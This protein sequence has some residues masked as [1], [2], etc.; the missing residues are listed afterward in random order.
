[1]SIDIFLKN[2]ILNLTLIKEIKMKNQPILTNNEKIEFCAKLKTSD[3]LNKVEGCYN[4]LK[5]IPIAGLFASIFCGGLL[6]IS[7]NPVWLSFLAPLFVTGVICPIIAL[8][9]IPTLVINLK[10]F[11]ELSHKK[12]SYKQ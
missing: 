5:M 6:L 1:M 7:G 8:M 12:L 3:A 10:E 9:P 2:D 11:K 4:F